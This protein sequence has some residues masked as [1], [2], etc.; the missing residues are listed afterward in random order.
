MKKLTQ[1]SIGNTQSGEEI[2]GI[3]LGC[4]Y[5]QPSHPWDANS[6]SA[7][8]EITSILSSPVFHFSFHESLPPLAHIISQTNQVHF[9]PTY[10]CKI[11]I[12]LLSTSKFS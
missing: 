12:I 7:T 9:L 4:N 3:E 1:V 2:S 8:Q 11:K 6:L 10:T 5:T